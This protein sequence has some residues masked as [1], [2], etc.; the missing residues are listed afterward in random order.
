MFRVGEQ[1]AVSSSGTY[2]S[3]VVAEELKAVS[4]SDTQQTVTGSETQQTVGLERKRL[5]LLLKNGRMSGSATR[6]TGAEKTLLI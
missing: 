5:W 4:R 3:V 1:K 6:L 2:K